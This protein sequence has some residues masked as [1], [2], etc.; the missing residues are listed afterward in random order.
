MEKRLLLVEDDADFREAFA[1]AL[2]EALAPEHPD[3]AFVGAGSVAEA[4][5][6]LREGGLDAALVGVALPDGDGLDLV[7]GIYDGG[8][9]SPM[10]TLVLTANLDP[11]AALR[12]LDAGADGA[13]SK[14]ASV[15]EV[16]GA[17]KRALGGG[18]S[19]A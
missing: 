14:A 6:R 17:I 19:E 5:A 8:V 15:R 12:A 13:Y 4:R 16:A 7:R 11:S 9:G 1:R 2:R 18:H 3:V 10:P